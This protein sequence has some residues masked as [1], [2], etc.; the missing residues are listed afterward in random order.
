MSYPQFP[1]LLRRF[2]P[3]ILPILLCSAQAHAEDPIRLG[4]LK[5]AHFAAVSYVKEIS[6]KEC[7]VQVSERTFAKGA[8]VMQGII[9]GEIDVGATASEAAIQGRAAGVPIFIVA[10][11]ATGGAR[12]LVRSD[13]PV[14]KV[15]E[16][17]GKRVAV[18]RGSI[19][20][21]LLAVELGQAG[22]TFSDQPGKDVQLTYLNYP[23][24]NQALL[25][26]NVDVIMQ[27]EPYSSQAIDRG[28]GIEV[29]KP[30]DTPIGSPVRTLV[31]TEK[32]Y[33][34]KPEQA[35]RFMQCFVKATGDFIR[36][37]KLASHYVRDVLFKGQLTEKEFA[38]AIG[39]APYGYDITPQHIQTTIDQM[40]KYGVGKLA[41]PPLATDFVRT[42]L[43]LAAKKQAGVE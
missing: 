30:Y 39:N 6:A 7:G 8:D 19:Q 24:L 9:A 23:D 35:K 3:S 29:L 15:A 31:M 1:A 18:T 17:K 25:T 4:N 12:L 34:E 13:Q 43:L 2:L 32:F 42:D 40:V 5:L 20:E 16:L 14:H 11:F 33:R 21:I 41:H 22:L 38:D 27:S 36:D 37:P 28:F 10:G 26:H